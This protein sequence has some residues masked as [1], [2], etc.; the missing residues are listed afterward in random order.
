MTLFAAGERRDRTPSGM[1]LSLHSDYALR[2]LMRLALEPERLVTI[3]EVAAGYGIS[4]AHLTKVVHGLAQRGCVETVRGRKGGLRLAQPASRLRIGQ[5]V[6][7]AERSMA[8]VECFDPDT[9]TCP[10]TPACRL[11]GVL[12][13]ALGEFLSALDRYTVADL[14]DRRAPALARLLRVN[15]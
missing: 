4:K 8:L 11:Q 9:D 2:V 10:V 12:R 5:I 3:E 14:I 7:D 13:E 6:A 15:G 1:Q